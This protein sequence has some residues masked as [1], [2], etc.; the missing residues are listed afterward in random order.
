MDGRNLIDRDRVRTETGPKPV[1]ISPD[2]VIW[3]RSAGGTPMTDRSI[4]LDA[5]DF[6]DPADRATFLDNTCGPDADL[7]RRVDALLTAHESQK[8]VARKPT[9][10]PPPGM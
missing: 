10:P 8:T 9:D 2:A 1:P 5:L 6:P 3:E 7:R 4:S